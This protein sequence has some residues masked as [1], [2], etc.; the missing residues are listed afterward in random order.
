MQKITRREFLDTAIAALGAG[1]VASFGCGALEV[2]SVDNPLASYPDRDWEKLYRDQYHYDRTFTWV[3][4]P[5][6]THMCR[7]RAF[8]RNGVVVRSEQNYDHQNYTDLYGNR[9]TPAWNPCACPKG[10]T[11]QRRVYGPYRLKGPVVRKG[12]KEW[13]DAGFPSLSDNPGCAANTSLTTAATTLS[14]R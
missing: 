7:L 3:C 6:D 5:N 10:Y 11:F 13:A 1:A 12:W 4:A 9:A 14:S 8:V 2:V